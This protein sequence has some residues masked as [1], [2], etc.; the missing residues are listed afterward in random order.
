MELA[1]RISRPPLRPMEM[2]AVEKHAGLRF[3]DSHH[4]PQPLAAL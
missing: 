4:H 3:L 1:L 2:E